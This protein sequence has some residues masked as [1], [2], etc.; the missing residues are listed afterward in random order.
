[1][2]FAGRNE[3]YLKILNDA[4]PRRAMAG[5]L[6]QLVPAALKPWV[7]LRC[8]WCHLHNLVVLELLGR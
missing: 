1:M 2:A 4:V 6:L 8:I 7:I 5:N 3:R